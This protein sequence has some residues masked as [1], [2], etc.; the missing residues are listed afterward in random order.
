[1]HVKARKILAAEDINIALWHPIS[2]KGLEYES[3]IALSPWSIDVSLVSESLD[4]LDLEKEFDHNDEVASKK[5]I[6]M[7]Q[8]M[9]DCLDNVNGIPT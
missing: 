9:K 4:D 6:H 3:V 1:M 5:E 8:N 2:I 7:N